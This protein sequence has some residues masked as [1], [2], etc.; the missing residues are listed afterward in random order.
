MHSSQSLWQL[1][2]FSLVILFHF[3]YQCIYSGKYR[4]YVF[5]ISGQ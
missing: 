3:F 2:Y 4:F 5:L 1:K